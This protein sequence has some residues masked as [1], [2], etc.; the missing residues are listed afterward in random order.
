MK[1]AG[2]PDKFTKMVSTFHVDVRAAVDSVAMLSTRV[3][4]YGRLAEERGEGLSAALTS[5]AASIERMES[6]QEGKV[7]L[8][9]GTSPEQHAANLASADA[10]LKAQTKVFK[11]QHAP[12]ASLNDVSHEKL[13]SAQKKKQEKAEDKVKL[14]AIAM[15]QK[16]EL[17]DMRANAA[18]TLKDAKAMHKQNLTQ[19]AASLKLE[20]YNQHEIDEKEAST[21][22]AQKKA[23]KDKVQID[24]FQKELNMIVEDRKVLEDSESDEDDV[25]EAEED[26]EIKEEE[27]KDEEDEEESDEEV[28]SPKPELVLHMVPSE[29]GSLVSVHAINKRASESMPNLRSKRSKV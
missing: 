21:V 10:A 16:Q 9:P 28:V 14:D 26:E 23:A 18:R 6:R 25:K 13:S 17:A 29:H 4:H 8:R 12:S 22:A 2:C 19:K 15:K 24:D 11:Q 7:V 27:I 1:V 20:K 5:I 3:E